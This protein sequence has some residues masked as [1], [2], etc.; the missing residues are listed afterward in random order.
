M[1]ELSVCLALLEQVQRVARE[2]HAQRV[3]KITLKI[4]PLSGVE[5]PLLKHAYPLASTGTLAEY[6]ELII[7]AIPIRVICTQCGAET[8][9]LP[10]RLLCG[11]CGD[12]RTRLVSGD[13]ML[14]GNVELTVDEKGSTTGD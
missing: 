5:V 14:L 3:E 11:E 13:E 10:N 6:A 8:E 1:H 9:A 4:G 12:F 2:Y 7:E